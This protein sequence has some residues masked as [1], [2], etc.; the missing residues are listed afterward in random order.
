VG[1]VPQQVGLVKRLLP[2]VDL[3]KQHNLNN[4]RVGSVSARNLLGQLVD[5][6]QDS[7]LELPLVGLVL[8][9]LS[10]QLP[11]RSVRLLPLQPQL[12]QQRALVVSELVLVLPVDSVKPNLHKLDSV[13]EQLAA[14]SLV[15]SLPVKRTHS[16]VTLN[17]IPRPLLLA[18]LVLL[19]SN[20]NLQLDLELGLLAVDY[21][22]LSLQVLALALE[23]E[24]CSEARNLPL[25]DSVD[26]VDSGINNNNHNSSSNNQA[27]DHSLYLVPAV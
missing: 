10:L 8:L 18:A 11:S 6:E 19:N 7:V 3:D 5:S 27:W 22:V 12:P 16:S 23:Q 13:L 25:V 1:S 15:Q 17:K 14:V 4:K 2:L 26:S 21:L 9:L 24:V 20:S